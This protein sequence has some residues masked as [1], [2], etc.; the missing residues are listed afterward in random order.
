MGRRFVYIVLMIAVVGILYYLEKKTPELVEQANGSAIESTTNPENEF[1]PDY[2]PKAN[3]QLIIHRLHALSYREDHEQAEWVAYQLR[4]E[5]LTDHDY[6]RPYFEEDPA[7]KTGAARYYN[8]KNTAYN[9]GHLLPAADRKQSKEAYAETFLMSNVS[10]QD[11]GF[12]SGIWNRLE[13]K[14]RYW[15]KKYDGVY[16][17]TGGVLEDGLPTIGEEAV[18]VPEYFYKIVVNVSDDRYRVSAFLIPNQK[19]SDSFYDYQ[20]TVDAIEARTGI[21]F[22]YELDPKMEAELESGSWKRLV[23]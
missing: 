20:V 6:K 9:K 14:V 18:S 17:V 16:V 13:Q 5:H 23:D 8:Y 1:G 7:V 4:P 15:A 12:N 21:D 2:L 11:P 3:G 19:T 10:P 22:F